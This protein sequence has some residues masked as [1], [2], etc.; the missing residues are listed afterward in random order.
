MI[1]YYISR[2]LSYKKYLINKNFALRNFSNY[3]L[4]ILISGKSGG[5]HYINFYK[6]FLRNLI[7]P[8]V[9]HLILKAYNVHFV[10]LIVLERHHY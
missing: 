7:F 4:K 8:N 9:Y 5:L 1:D 10:Q 6:H 3:F 2:G